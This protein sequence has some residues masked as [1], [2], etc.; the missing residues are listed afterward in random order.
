MRRR[1]TRGLGARLLEEVCAW[2]ESRGYLAVTLSTFRDVPWNGRFYRKRGFRDL[3][4][5]EWSPGM[6][7]IREHEAKHGLRVDVRVFVRRELAPRAFRDGKDGPLRI[8]AVC[9]SLA[10]TSVAS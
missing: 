7:A 9:G 10:A 5:E 1:A 4:P 6:M 2:A 8:T 3:H